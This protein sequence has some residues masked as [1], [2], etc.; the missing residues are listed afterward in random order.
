MGYSSFSLSIPVGYDINQPLNFA[1]TA[2]IVSNYSPYYLYFAD[3]VNFCPPWTSGAVIPLSHAT[4]GRASWGYTP[5]GVQTITTPPEGVTYIA[6][7]VFTDDPSLSLSGGTLVVVPADTRSVSFSAT[8]GASVV[9]G[10]LS[11]PTIGCRVDNNTGTWYQIGT[12]G[13][14][15]PPYTTGFTV[16]LLPAIN[17]LTVAPTTPPY[18]NPNNTNGTGITVTLYAGYIG[19][20]SGNTVIVDYPIQLLQS[21]TLTTSTLNSTITLPTPATAGNLLVAVFAS[22][23]STASVTVTGPAGWTTIYTS[24]AATTVCWIGY[25][26]AVGGEANAL[27]TLPG[28]TDIANSICIAEYTAFNHGVFQNANAAGSTAT[29]TPITSPL[30]AI[31]LSAYST[32]AAAAGTVTSVN[33]IIRASITKAGATTP[34]TGAAISDLTYGDVSAKTVTLVWSGGAALRTAIITGE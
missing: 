31:G 30:I 1:P 2:V 25:K 8:P 13:F 16:D 27:F 17:S 21:N 28:G 18:G 22:A 4:R 3:A 14:L 23:N 5:F 34:R 19:N 32:T 26:V 6:N 20:S 29:A 9:T 11:Y 24:L 33:T 7:L 12:T 10:A 15:I